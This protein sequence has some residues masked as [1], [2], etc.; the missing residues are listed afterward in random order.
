MEP[1]S[2]SSSDPGRKPGVSWFLGKIFLFLLGGLLLLVP[3]CVA[4]LRADRAA[5]DSQVLK[6][7]P[8][9][10]LMIAG[11][12][13][14]ET[15]INPEMLTN[16]VSVARS[17]ERY[18]YTYF[19]I[20]HLID[21]NPQVKTVVLG[22]SPHN[23][24]NRDKNLYEDR[25]N[26]WKDYFLILDT[27]ARQQLAT[28]RLPYVVAFLRSEYGMPFRLFR[29]PIVLNYILGRTV[30]KRDDLAFI[31][32][33]LPL[34]RSTLNTSKISKRVNDHFRNGKQYAGSSSIMLD[35][36]HKIA[37]LCSDHGIKLILL[38][39]P[40]TD[41]Y[42]ELI[43]MEACGEFH[44]VTTRLTREFSN[45]MYCD[46]S[47]FSLQPNN[48]SDGDH[49]NSSGAHIFTKYLADNYPEFVSMRLDGKMN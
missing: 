32:G 4:S 21:K 23:I 31:G 17:A 7:G 19:K 10:T 34:Q 43:P 39:T 13:H 29:D 45:V 9:K 33:Y 40:V 35:Y 14:T 12:S 8:D 11:D 42:R 25:V 46:L 47:T 16:A 41:T 27:P 37:T 49:L 48:F 15:S 24:M 22:F 5:L 1:S 30:N 38:N 28:F 3:L 18:F 36:L 44:Q 6:F 2:T 20:K 26:M